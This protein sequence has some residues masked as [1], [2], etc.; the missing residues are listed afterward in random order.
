MATVSPAPGAWAHAYLL[1][2]LGRHYYGAPVP[3]TSAEVGQLLRRLCV[4]FRQTSFSSCLMMPSGEQ[5]ALYQ[6][7]TKETIDALATWLEHERAQVVLEVGAGDGLLTHWLRARLRDIPIRLI[8]TDNGSWQTSASLHWPHRAENVWQLTAAQALARFQPDTVLSSWM[9][10]GEDWT[11]R[12][13]MCRS[14]SR[15]V[16]IGEG[17][18]GAVATESAWDPHPDWLARPIPDFEEGAWCRTD[19][20]DQ[21]GRGAFRHTQAW[22]WVRLVPEA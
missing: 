16:L 14:V 22:G 3:P 8:A 1:D 10:W 6:I 12:F 2:W 17:R 9:P 4:R 18:G 11:G 21:A 7:W 20:W 19:W 5:L 13:R 15:Y